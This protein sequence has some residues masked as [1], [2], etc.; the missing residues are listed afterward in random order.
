[1]REKSFVRNEIHYA[2]AIGRPIFVA[3]FADIDPPLTVIDLTWLDFFKDDWEG[4]V[5]RLCS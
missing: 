1:L 2:R 5:N 3:R 4:C